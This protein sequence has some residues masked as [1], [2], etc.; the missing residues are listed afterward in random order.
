MDDQ[1]GPEA[2]DATG[3]FHVTAWHSDLGDLVARARSALDVRLEGQGE[4]HTLLGKEAV[5]ADFTAWLDDFAR[6]WTRGRDE[7]DDEASD[8]PDHRAGGAVARGSGGG[9]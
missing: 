9:A 4:A 6:G 1:D 5:A 8:P 3:L 7:P 2:P